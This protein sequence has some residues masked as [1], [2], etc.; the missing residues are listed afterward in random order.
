MKII[1]K[2][3]D[4]AVNVLAQPLLSKK[5]SYD[6][7]ILAKYLCH[8]KKMNPEEIYEELVHIMDE[9]YENFS[10]AAWQELLLDLAKNASKRPLTDIESLPIT[11]SELAVVDSIISKPMRRIAFT[12]LCLARYRTFVQPE[13]QGW[14]NYEFRDIFKMANVN[15]SVKEQCRI[16]YDLQSLNLLEMNKMVD[17]LSLHILFLSPIHSDAVLQ[18]SDFRN[19]GYEYLLYTGEKFFRCEKCG[20]L[21][22]RKS[23]RCKYC[24]NCGED[25]DREKAQKR[26][27][28]LRGT[29]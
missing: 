7:R 25:I 4:Y 3:T 11:V 27:R 14:I 1:L 9:K 2:E 28:L 20:L 8:S 16:I 18:I 21:V 15:A 6:L 13:S 29:V 5:P 10:I 22:R 19:L 12:L 17:N 26:M 24:K 23:N